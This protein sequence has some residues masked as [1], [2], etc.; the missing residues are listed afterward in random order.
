MPTA[1]AIKGGTVKGT[2]HPLYKNGEAKWRD[3][4]KWSQHQFVCYDGEGINEIIDGVEI[5]HYV[6]L[7]AYNGKEYYEVENHKGLSTHECFKFLV[8]TQAKN[9]QYGIAVIYGGN[10]DT[11]MMLKDINLKTLKL[12]NAGDRVFW[13]G[14]SIQ[15]INRKY[16]SVK[17][18]KTGYSIRLW[19]V[20]GFF[21]DKFATSIENWLGVTDSVIDIGKATRGLFTFDEFDTMVEYCQRELLY[22]EQLMQALWTALHNA[23][24]KNRQRWAREGKQG[25]TQ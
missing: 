6:Y 18:M 20:I 15:Y 3:K 21:Q 19:D 11:N 12:I 23:G 25:T 7:A 17:H 13:E 22:F 24:F 4:T 2:N 16:L 5:Q 1:I 9:R 8:K 14:Y 10:Y